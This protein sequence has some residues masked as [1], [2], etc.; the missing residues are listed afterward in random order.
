MA[1]FGSVYLDDS[2]DAMRTMSEDDY[3]AAQERRLSRRARREEEDV[4][5]DYFEEMQLEREED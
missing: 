4:D 3:Y 1:G 2:Y 5:G